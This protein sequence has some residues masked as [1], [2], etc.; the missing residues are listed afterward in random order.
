[1]RLMPRICLVLLALF[2]SL[3]GF[4]QEKA[5]PLKNILADI[6]SQHRVTFN[7]IED[8]VIVYKIV[9]PKKQW[10]LET[11]LDYIKKRTRLDFRPIGASSY[12]VYNDKKLDK[13]L[14]GFLKDAETGKPVEAASVII[15]NTNI[16]SVSDANGYFELPVVSP[17]AISIRH[18]NYEFYT[19]SP[20]DLYQP[21][22]PDISLRPIVNSLEEIVA[23][24]YLTT[25]ISKNPDGTFRVTPKNFGILPGQD[26]PDVQQTMQQLPGINSE[27]ETIS[28]ISVR[29]GTHD[30]NLFLWNGIRMFQTGHFFGMISVFNPALPQTVTIAKN[31]TD[32]FFGES[33]SSLVDISTHS[34]KI[35]ES[36]TI[37]SGDMISVQGA[38]NIRLSE[39]S[40][41][42]FSVRRSYADILTTP[43]YINYRK[44]IFQNTIVTDLGDDQTVDIKSD[45]HF[46]FCDFTMQFQQN[47]G[48]HNFTADVIG[49]TNNLII[50]QFSEAVEKNNDLGQR[51]Y[52]ASANWTSDWDSKNQTGLNAYISYYNLNSSTET[53]ASG[54]L[55]EQKNTVL[56]KGLRLS[57]IWKAS[58]NLTLSGGYQ[59]NETGI[60]NSDKINS[61]LFS[62]KITDVMRTHVAVA[63][64]TINPES[65]IMLLKAGFRMNYFQ[66]LNVFVPEIR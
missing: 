31:G 54:Q 42:G 12:T 64:A 51:N 49:I 41:I 43:T 20:A 50:D 10:T 53:F 34:K 66:D 38:T 11:K 56:D 16:S 23:Q 3:S 19:I 36:K 15:A 60:S 44:R 14:C 45:E 22:C 59:F 47:F 29:G 18:Q 4:S 65:K 6:A 62:R 37:L 9:P 40:A 26:Q 27:D 5:I 61:P 33:V 63:E 8:E 1:M 35:S 2:L 48:R 46:Y 28:N 58:S 21:G 13:P 52:G 7:F 30:Q 55:L 57:H 25:G 39:K 32:G 17:N 24:R